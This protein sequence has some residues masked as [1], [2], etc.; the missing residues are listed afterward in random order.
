MSLTAQVKSELVRVPVGNSET[1]RAELAALLRFAGT[2]QVLS[3]R[4]VIEAE[5]DSGD[6]ADRVAGEL[7]SLFGVS[8]EIHPIGG[9]GGRAARKFVLRVMNRGADL[10]RQLGLVDTTGRG[11]RGF[12]PPSSARSP[13]KLPGEALAHGSRPSLT[14]VPRSR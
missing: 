9:S 10:A 2:L 13:P 3:G 7:D 1:R 12:R 5:V 14:L 11:V 8:C 4:L 6:I